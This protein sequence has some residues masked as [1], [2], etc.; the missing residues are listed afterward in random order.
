MWSRANWA[1]PSRR[2]SASFH[3]SGP[4]QNTGPRPGCS[5][6][7]QKPG[8]A[9]PTTRCIT[10]VLK[11]ALRTRPHHRQ[12]EGDSEGDGAS[13]PSIGL[14]ENGTSRENFRGPHQARR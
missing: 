6:E 2:D 10:P 3:R 1:S 7:F 11:A 4:F 9:A 13:S 8:A 14:G 5:L 12:H